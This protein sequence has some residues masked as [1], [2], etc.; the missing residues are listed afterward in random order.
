MPLN[1]Y[2][3]KKFD[4]FC[5]HVND[6]LKE[7]LITDRYEPNFEGVVT[8]RKNSEIVGATRNIR[9]TEDLLKS[10]K[11]TKPSMNKGLIS[12]DADHASS[13]YFLTRGG[14]PWIERYVTETTKEGFA[15]KFKKAKK[16]KTR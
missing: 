12:Y 13:V 16:Q 14:R 5:Q 4:A 15:E 8:K 2:I 3:T 11:L 9:D 1:D 6:D 7:E 10:Q